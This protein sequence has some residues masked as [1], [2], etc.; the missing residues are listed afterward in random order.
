MGFFYISWL[1]IFF[2]AP[3]AAMLGCFI[4]WRRIAFFTDSLAHASV[5]GLALA[6]IFDF[7][8][9]L[10]IL[11]VSLLVTLFVWLTNRRREL[12][13]DAML[14]ITAHFLLGVG[15]LCVSLVELRVDLLS[16]LLGEWLLLNLTDLY[17][18]AGISIIVITVLWLLHKPLLALVTQSE[19]A[20]A[21]GVAKNRLDLLFFLLLTIFITI[22]I[23]TVGLLLISSLMIMPAAIARN[24]V[25]NPYHMLWLSILFA[26]LILFSGLA[27]SLSLDV[28]AS[29]AA[30]S[31]G[32]IL[33]LLSWL[34]RSRF[35]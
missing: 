28:P 20:Q 32:G 34:I 31:V 24:W 19:I 25:K 8:Q 7:S 15:I 35:N 11:A 2:L 9:T 18:Q 30:A 3:P 5:L 6:F 26:L 22:S 12:A 1:M 27:L 16:Y 23:Q 13:S 21:E 10:G 29:P 17:L 33:F 14:S 4:F